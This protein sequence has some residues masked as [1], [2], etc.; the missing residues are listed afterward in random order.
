MTNPLADMLKQY[1]IETVEDSVNALKEIIQEVVLVGLWRSNFFEEAAFYGGTALRILY[2]LDR[3]SE[4]LDFSLLA[5][6]TTFSWE[7]YAGALQEELLAYGI[8]THIT[9]KTKNKQSAIQS[10][11]IKANTL[12][13]MLQTDLSFQER[14]QVHVG[15]QIKVR[16]EIDTDPP[17]LF[18][19]ATQHLLQPVEVAI[20]SFSLP[21]QFAGKMH[22]LLC[23]GWKSRVKGR[24]WWDM[25]WFVKRGVPIHLAHLE[26]RM[27]QSGHIDSL[28]TDRF[29][30]LL[31]EKID[32]LP[33]ES[34]KQ[35]LLPF[36]ADPS[37]LEVWSPEFFKS[38]ADRIEL[39]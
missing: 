7:R 14:R 37:R 12:E 26:A 38:V 32:N 16:I 29:R 19:T 4:D 8:Q 24:D 27:Q 15:Q 33:I 23:R 22:A 36:I 18:E 10:A 39:T 31:L 13:H 3:F 17:P 30:S 2:G 34:A 6:S 9:E 25:I 5:P 20:R 35:D 21:D 1:K 11:F 28:S